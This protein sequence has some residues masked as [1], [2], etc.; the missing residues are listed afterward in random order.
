M[1]IDCHGHYT[2]APPQLGAYRDAQKAALA[3]DPD[4]IGDKGSIDIS[5]DEIVESLEGNQL[6]LQ[7]ERGIDL[8]LRRTQGAAENLALLRDPAS[9]VQ[10]GFVQGGI[11]GD[12]DQP[13][14]DTP[15]L[16]SLG[17][18]ALPVKTEPLALAAQSA[19]QAFAASKVHVEKQVPLE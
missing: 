15:P 6:R 11:A 1:I 4:H 5:D 19:P 18:V 2:T 7:R 9:G 17:S 10:A 14:E 13:A 16:A 12:A 8:T 3:T